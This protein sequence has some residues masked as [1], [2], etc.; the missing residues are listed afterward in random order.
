MF[1]NCTFSCSQYAE[2]LVLQSHWCCQSSTL[3]IKKEASQKNL[4]DETC[5]GGHRRAI[6]RQA[7]WMTDS[8]RGSQS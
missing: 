7:M 4:A 6:C 5:R 3:K 1:T 8:D 2:T